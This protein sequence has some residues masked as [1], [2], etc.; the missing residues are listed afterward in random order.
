MIDACYRKSI[1]LLLKISLSEGF[2]ASSATAHYAAIWARD[3]CITSIGANLTEDK[4]LLETSKNTL[5]TPA[6]LQAPQEQ[7][8]AVY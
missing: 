1:V 5:L 2:V 7:I 3:A 6:N 8:P 4:K